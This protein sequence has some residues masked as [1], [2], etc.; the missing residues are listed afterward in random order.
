MGLLLQVI[1]GVLVQS[2]PGSTTRVGL[3]GKGKKKKQIYLQARRGGCRP[4]SFHFS[5]DRK[6]TIAMDLFLATRSRE[7]HGAMAC[8]V[9]A[10]LVGKVSSATHVWTPPLFLIV[11]LRSAHHLRFSHAANCE[12]HL[13]R[14]PCN[15]EV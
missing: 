10:G 7:P 1:F 12:L 13:P 11:E 14:G 8:V 6:R 4:E 15:F 5:A 3:R 2:K 9:W